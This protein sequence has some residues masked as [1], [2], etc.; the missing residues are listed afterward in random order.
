MDVETTGIDPG[1]NS[2]WEIGFIITDIDLDVKCARSFRIA[3]LDNTEIDLKALELNHITEQELK[4]FEDPN[5]VRRQLLVI[6]DKYVNKFNPADK[7]FFLGYNA[8]FDYNFLY[9]WF[10]KQ[11]FKFLGSYFHSP[12]LDIMSLAGIELMDKRSTVATELGVEVDETR[13]HEALYDIELTLQIYKLI[14][15]E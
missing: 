2:I 3:P 12:P 11:E 14:R 13:L 6:F 7:F 9:S 5:S 10:T 15:K 1:V 8:R 4:S